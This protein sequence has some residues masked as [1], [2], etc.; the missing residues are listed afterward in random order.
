MK[1]ADIFI[2][3][4][5]PFILFIIFGVNVCCCMN[6]IDI[7]DSYAL[8]GNSFLYALGMFLISLS[9]KKYHCVWNRAMYAFLIIVPIINY[10]DLK[11]TLFEDMDS[12]LIFIRILFLVTTLITAYLA[13]RHFWKT[14]T[15][16]INHGREQV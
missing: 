2:I 13:M 15:K 16:K 12:Y 14:I 6:G 8:H 5:L 3:R 10:I 9:N 4:F 1:K 7:M 11:I